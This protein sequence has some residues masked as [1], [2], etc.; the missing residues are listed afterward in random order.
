MGTISKVQDEL[1]SVDN[2]VLDAELDKYD[3]VY[4]TFDLQFLVYTQAVFGYRKIRQIW[5]KEVNHF[6]QKWVAY[7]QNF[8]EFFDSLD[9]GNKKRLVDWMV[10]QYKDDE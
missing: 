8:L 4:K 10:V 5:P 7:N 2:K 9:N 3:Y 6:S 1:N